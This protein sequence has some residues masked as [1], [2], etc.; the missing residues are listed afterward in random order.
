MSMRHGV[1]VAAGDQEVAADDPVATLGVDRR[2]TQT[3]GF[4]LAAGDDV[5]QAG[6]LEKAT[7]VVLGV[8]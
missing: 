1:T 5:T 4:E 7:M 6:D 8:K 3:G 2:I